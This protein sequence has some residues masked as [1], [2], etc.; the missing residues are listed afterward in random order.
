MI[1]VIFWATGVL[2]WALVAG[3]VLWFLLT[4]IFEAVD[5]TW[6]TV[7]CWREGALKANTLTNAWGIWR[8][9]L[10]GHISSVRT[11]ADDGYYI[12]YPGYPWT[13]LREDD[14]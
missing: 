7:R 4:L 10:W 1:D 6:F 8:H 12:P 3:L 5:A 2:A 13:P 9:G 11:K 14:E